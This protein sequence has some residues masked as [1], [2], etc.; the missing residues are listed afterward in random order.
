MFTEDPLR[1]ER[2]GEH[3]ILIAYCLSLSVLNMAF[4]FIAR[5]RTAQDSLVMVLITHQIPRAI[6]RR[7]CER[8]IFDGL[9]MAEDLSNGNFWVRI[10]YKKL[11]D[12]LEQFKRAFQRL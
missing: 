10:H 4:D 11:K 3:G 8:Q 1:F 2:D 7:A 9:Q 12:G 6:L 5:S